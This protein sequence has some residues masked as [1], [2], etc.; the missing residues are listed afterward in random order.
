MVNFKKVNPNPNLNLTIFLLIN[1]LRR[2]QRAERRAQ[3]ARV[4][5]GDGACG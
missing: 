3:G 4:G 1:H 5:P 2:G